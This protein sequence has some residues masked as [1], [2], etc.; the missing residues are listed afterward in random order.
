ML[1][2]ALASVLLL[3]LA[4]P[5]SAQQNQQKMSWH[6]QEGEDTAALVYGVPDSDDGVI[7]FLCKPGTPGLMVQS[8]IGSKDLAREANTPLVI[9][10]G[11]T[12]KSF[13]GKG[14]AAEDVERID[15][16]APAQ[17]ADVKALAKA[18]GPVTVEVKGA[19]GTVSLSGLA[20]L[21]AKFEA[22][23][24]AKPAPKE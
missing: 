19:K 6:L 21:V 9:T 20:P 11:R 14:V 17:M 2:P 16:E 24:K 23:C 5:A 3:A 7:F 15:V 10:A 18:S 13:S 1:R 8:M 4:V 12:K 22:A